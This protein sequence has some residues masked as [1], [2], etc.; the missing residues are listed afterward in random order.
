[1]LRRIRYA[2]VGL[3]ALFSS[4][5]GAADLAPQATSLQ[6]I[7]ADAA[8]YT[9][10]FQ[11]GTQLQRIVQ[12]N[13]FKK[14]EQHP[15]VQ[16][17]MAQA[18]NYWQAE[19][20][21]LSEML[22]MPENQALLSL[23]REAVAEEMFWYAD[24]NTVEWLAAMMKL[25]NEINAAQYEAI[26]SDDDVDE[27][28]LVQQAILRTIDKLDLAL[29][30]GIV[31]GFKSDNVD[32]LNRQLQ[33]AFDALQAAMESEE[34]LAPLQDSLQLDDRDGQK[35]LTFRFDGNKIP[36]DEVIEEDEIRDVFGDKLKQLKFEVSLTHHQGYIVL[37][38]G[39]DQSVLTKLGQ[40]EKLLDRKEMAPLR[41]LSSAALT[42]VVYVSERM[43]KSANSVDRAIDQYAQLA[44]ALVKSEEMELE[45]QQREKISAD[46][47]AFRQ[48]L[49]AAITVHVG[50][51]SG[52]SLMTDD[53]YEGYQYDWAEREPLDVK[54]LQ[55][56]QHVGGSP[57]FF[58][59]G[60]NQSQPEWNEL[61]KKWAPRV[62]AYIDEVARQELEDQPEELEAYDALV[63][64]GGPLLNKLGQI[65]ETKL[66]P[67]F[68]GGETAIVIDTE[69]RSDQWHAM[70]PAGEKLPMFEFASVC[71][72]SN[73]QL[74][75]EGF[76]ETF[77]VAQSMVDLMVEL[78]HD[79]EFPITSIPEPDVQDVAGG[80]MYSYSLPDQAQLDEAIRPNALMVNN[81][82]IV[83]TMP[84]TSQR[85]SASASPQIKGILANEIARPLVA[86]SYCDMSKFWS[87][88]NEWA[89][90]GANLT[91]NDL[92]P[93]QVFLDAIAC[94]DGFSAVV[95]QTDEALV[96]HYDV[97]FQDL[98][99]DE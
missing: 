42:S 41:Q 43:A 51:L 72:M 64:R 83:S 81:L 87:A 23:V 29:W 73:P 62:F 17:G 82:V 77:Q 9:G 80:K 86:A 11:W 57:L 1:M 27:E 91:G 55:L 19:S 12:S 36:W 58:A 3:L 25:S 99:A 6:F 96:T 39:R 67:A 59:I 44:Q 46:I 76:A 45:P 38:M 52:Y 24:D 92:S 15:L 30:P 10:S 75:T 14:L 98:P 60:H 79:G 48:D 85:L 13:A 78:D 21:P 34:E 88:I 66:G 93:Y 5:A 35:S 50:A 56:V 95:Y 2:T 63:T 16:M 33:R 74:A 40:G 49:R 31:I 68:D 37:V 18:L 32:E 71:S 26:S 89:Q 28:E 20:G 47:E 65:M 7:P 84:E 4:L 94:F 70:L 22:T 54:P 61:C 69:A 90:F 53:G 97:R 8:I